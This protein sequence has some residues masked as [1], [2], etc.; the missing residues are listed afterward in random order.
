MLLMLVLGELAVRVCRWVLVGVTVEGGG[1]CAYNLA[2]L[3]L[4]P[5]FACFW[6]M[7][8]GEDSVGG[9]VWVGW[10]Y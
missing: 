10:Q 3:A 2:A 5:V 4:G 9:Q 8:L 1:H 7:M 6:G